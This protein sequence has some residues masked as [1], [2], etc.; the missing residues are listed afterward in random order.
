[1]VA[2][3]ADFLQLSRYK[4][5]DAT[6]NPSLI[7]KAVTDSRYADLV[8]RV[9]SEHQG[10]SIQEISDQLL[11]RFGCEILCSVPGR[12]STEVDARLSFDCD[13]T[14]D[15]AQRL[16]RLYERAGVPR[17]RILIKIASTWSG[18]RAAGML[19]R[20][21]IHCNLT[22]V[23]GLHQ[24]TACANE[25][26]RLI[27]PFV[28]RIY[29][30]H[31]KQAGQSWVEAEHAGDEDPGVQSVKQIYALYK[32]FAVPTQVMAASFR[33]IGQILAL[34]GCDLMTI[35]P[36]LLDALENQVGEVPR[37]LKPEEMSDQSG[38]LMALSERDFEAALEADVMARTKL[39]EGITT[40][41]EDARKLDLVLEREVGLT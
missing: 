23:F 37:K 1:V 29:D 36:D 24:A 20:E 38:G 22:L 21:G 41:C 2:D 8:R 30:W 28:G 15:K 10:A 31:K 14:V 33:N 13:A 4:P 40:F 35:S 26:V 16:I 34:S 12:V 11:V 19:E 7:L 39:S 17:S 32:N 9:C 18:I 6:T 5:Q 25:G 3:T 27:S